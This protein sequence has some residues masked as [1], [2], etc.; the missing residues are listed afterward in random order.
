MMTALTQRYLS[1]CVIFFL[2]VR[3]GN[4]SRHFFPTSTFAGLR[5][6]DLQF[7]IRPTPKPR[8]PSNI[9]KRFADDPA[10]CGWVEGNDSKFLSRDIIFETNLNLKLSR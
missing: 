7:N 2:S 4:T 3:L 9:S 6:A 10:I 8:T 5:P 1:T